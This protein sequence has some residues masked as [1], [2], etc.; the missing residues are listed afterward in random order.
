[1]VSNSDSLPEMPESTVRPG[2]S[3]LDRLL[4]SCGRGAG[5]GHMED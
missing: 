1:M 4:W 3:S 2:K 5:F